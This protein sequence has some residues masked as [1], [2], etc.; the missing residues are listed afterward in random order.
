[1]HLV[2]H[3][4]ASS[5]PPSAV[6]SVICNVAAAPASR[7][8]HCQCYLL[9]KTICTPPNSLCRVVTEAHLVP[10]AQTAR[11]C[12]ESDASGMYYFNWETGESRWTHPCDDAA[13]ETFQRE[14][15]RWQAAEQQGEVYSQPQQLARETSSG[16]V[17]CRGDGAGVAQ[18]AQGVTE[19]T[20]QRIGGAEPDSSAA[21][22][23]EA[24]KLQHARE[25]AAV[26]LRHEEEMRALRMCVQA[27]AQAESS[28]LRA[29]AEDLRQQIASMESSLQ[30]DARSP[31]AN[32]MGKA[33]SSTQVRDVVC[34]QAVP[35][36]L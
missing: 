35:S 7:M 18:A 19:S 10:V 8:Y 11:A 30:Y 20:E 6:A 33:R 4:S 2:L 5:G 3:V 14:L 15:E 13:T 28:R 23:V 29:E 17:A 21:A 36:F 22:T 32:V 25:A 31:S 24:I 9:T 12:S 34:W 1:M 27:D 16:D 26:K